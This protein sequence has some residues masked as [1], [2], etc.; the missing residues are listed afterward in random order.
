MVPP[1]G[2]APGQACAAP[3]TLRCRRIL[4]HLAPPRASLPSQP[5][6]ATT[7]AS[8][9]AAPADPAISARHPPAAAMKTL[10]RE[11]VAA[12]VREGYVVL[13]IDEVDPDAHARIYEH[14]RVNQGGSVFNGGQNQKE[15]NRSAGSLGEL[16]EQQKQLFCEDYL[17]V[18]ESPT[19]LGAMHSLLGPDFCGFSNHL[20]GGGGEPGAAGGLR[21]PNSLVSST[22]DN[23]HHKDG[24]G[25]A[26][27]EHRF[28]SVGYWYYPHDVDVV[29]GPT[30]VVP[31]SHFW[32]VD[33]N[34]FPHSEERLDRAL[35]P[36]KPIEA[37]RD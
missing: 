3:A 10:S 16:T 15:Y 36:P 19:I 28:R 22:G 21:L 4:G 27:R 26:V 17:R 14:A 7:A 31:K 13:S 34:T 6:P 1:M 9:A 18:A 37:W 35:L 30:C 20:Q 25:L 5:E 12:F 8:A 33:R 24:T 23:Q 29:M 2:P 32:A 11:Q